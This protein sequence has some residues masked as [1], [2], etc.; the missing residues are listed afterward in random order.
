M[1]PRPTAP[2]DAASV[3]A[4]LGDAT[5]WRVQSIGTTGSTNTDLA[6]Q[7][8]AGAIEPGQV[9]IAQEQTAGRGRLG[10]GWQAPYGS[11]Q[12]L[13]VLVRPDGVPL[14]RRG[15]IGAI[16]GLALV[17]AI[18]E[19]CGVRASLKWPN[20]LLLDGCKGAGILAEVA[21]DA[22]VVGAGLNLDLSREEYPPRAAGSTALTPISLT[23]AR[24]A[25][26]V[27]DRVAL[28]AATLSSFATLLDRWIVAGGDMADSGLLEQYRQRCDSLG[29]DVRVELFDGSSVTG[30]G[31]DIGDDGSL[32][33]RTSPPGRP[34]QLRSFSAADVVHLRPTLRGQPGPHPDLYIFHPH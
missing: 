23:E 1:N 32:V 11:S 12:I 2:L 14:A 9:L 10:R 6:A 28:A 34:A 13:S 20:D 16:L 29:R 33:V 26:A 18:H 15:W 3:E 24:P 5:R 8:L 7:Y 30:V 17:E 31:H 22:L 4:A 27:L 19:C 21:G 25:G